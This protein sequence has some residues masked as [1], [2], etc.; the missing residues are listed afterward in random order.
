[1]SRRAPPGRMALLLFALA[2]SAACAQQ[3]ETPGHGRESS[4]AGVAVDTEVMAY[5]SMARARHHEANLKEDDDVPAAIVVL[6]R[7]TTA[8]RPHPGQR[9]PEIEEV[10]ADTFARIAELC[11]RKGDLAKASDSVR[12]GLTHAEAASYFRGHLLEIGGIIEE[13][14]AAA[15]RDAGQQAQAAAAKA[16][17]LDLLHQAVLV[18]ERVVDQSL[19]AGAGRDGGSK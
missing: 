17:A 1:M 13:S 14:R 11:V 16:R 5:L 3:R 12:E 19:A 10:L 6:D 7:V 4:E 9:I 18:Q 8:K 2:A 15:L